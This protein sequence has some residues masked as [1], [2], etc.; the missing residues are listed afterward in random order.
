MPTPLYRDGLLYWIDQNGKAVCLDAETGKTVYQQKLALVGI[1]DKIYASLVLGDGKL[2]GV[3][4]QSGTIVLAA[5]KEFK[6]IARNDPLDKSVFNGTP[7]I[8]GGRLLI[9]SNLCLYC[10]GK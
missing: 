7:A 1:G 9:R 5:G 10:I 3:T 8:S 6:E 2:Y 4:R